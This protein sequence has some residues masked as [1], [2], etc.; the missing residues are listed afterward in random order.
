VGQGTLMT[1]T[2]PRLATGPGA[3]AEAPPAAPGRR[4]DGVRVLLVED[5][6]DTRDLISTVLA[7]R[8]ARVA[9][10]GSVVEASRLFDAGRPDIVLSDIGLPGEDGFALVR[11]LRRRAPEDGGLVPA[12]AITAFAR[13]EDR[14]RA[15]QAGFQA[16]LSKPVDPE[17]VVSLVAHYLGAGR[18]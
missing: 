7:A 9:A 17:D 2:L 6:D 1:V 4:L 18:G 15:L 10:A 11:A 16:H 8:G 3:A 13:A 12:V 5:D 14:A